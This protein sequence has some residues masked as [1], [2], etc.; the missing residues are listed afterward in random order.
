[1]LASKCDDVS[2]S[3]VIRALNLE[4]DPKLEDIEE[5]MERYSDE[6]KELRKTK[7]G[8][9]KLAKGLSFSS[10]CRRYFKPSVR[11]RR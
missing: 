10:Q 11:N 2:C 6:L 3:E 5:R 8:A 4:D 1:M 9:E 7:T